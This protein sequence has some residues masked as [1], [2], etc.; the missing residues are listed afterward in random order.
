VF[1][2]AEETGEIPKA[3]MKTD[4]VIEDIEITTEKIVKKIAKLKSASAAGPDGIG[5]LL[6]QQP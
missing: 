2:S 6:L 3:D 4:Q 5:A 1:F